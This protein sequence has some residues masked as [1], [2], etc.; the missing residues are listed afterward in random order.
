MR[1]GKVMIG[2]LVAT[3]LIA[4][5][6]FLA[7]SNSAVEAT[8]QCD[9]PYFYT[10]S[11]DFSD[12]RVEIDF[13][14]TGAQGNPDTISVSGKNGYEV[15]DVWL[16][17]DGVNVVDYDYHFNG[18]VTN[19]NP[20]G[21]T[22]VEAKVRVVKPCP[23]PTPTPTESLTPTPTEEPTPTP[24]P[25]EEPSPTPTPTEEPT[26]TP[27]P[28]ETPAPQPKSEPGP[29]GAPVCTDSTPLV[30]PSN[31]HVLRAGSEATVNFFTQSANANIYFKEVS[32]VNWQHSVRDIA[33]TGG[34][35][36]YTVR[37]LDPMLGYTFGVQAA[38]SCAGGETVLAVVV[39]GP[40]PVLFPFSYWEWLK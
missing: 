1:A 22:I 38:N 10:K 12:A 4:L 25:T 37:D 5:G 35:V 32:E 6:G 40:E 26:P 28:E 33:V 36:S 21:T 23:T 29:A 7:F 16:E 20:Q 11:Q 17:V 24:T 13:D 19:E 8:G 31:V 34:Y 18:P 15:T 30:V 9:T 14:N 2:T 39:D 27:E 3:V